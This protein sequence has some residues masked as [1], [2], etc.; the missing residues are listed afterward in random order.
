MTVRPSSLR[1]STKLRARIACV[2]ALVFYVLGG[3]PGA[4]AQAPHALQWA[5]CGGRL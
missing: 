3:P 1:V 5:D 4:L 2:G